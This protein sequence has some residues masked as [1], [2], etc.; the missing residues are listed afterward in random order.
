MQTR[1]Q[2]LELQRQAPRRDDVLDRGHRVGRG[3]RRRASRDREHDVLAPGADE[4]WN[5]DDDPDCSTRSDH[6]RATGVTLS[7]VCLPADFLVRRRRASEGADRSGE[8]PRRDRG[9]SE[10]A[11]LRHDVT[12]W[13]R[14]ASD[15]GDFE[16]KLPTVG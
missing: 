7:G 11:Y 16:N 15:V 4:S 5:L 12:K 2:H 8:A 14:A 1:L 13:K 9:R 6:G 10:C 3:E